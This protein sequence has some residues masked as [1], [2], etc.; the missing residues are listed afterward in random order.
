MER[1]FEFYEIV[2]DSKRL[3]QFREE[4]VNTTKQPLLYKVMSSSPEWFRSKGIYERKNG[5]FEFAISPLRDY[6]SSYGNFANNFVRNGAS[7]GSQVK[8]VNF[9]GNTYYLYTNSNIYKAG[10][11]YVVKPALLINEDIYNLTKLQF[12]QFLALADGDASKYKDFFSVKDTAYAS[13]SIDRCE[14]IA[15]SEFSNEEDILKAYEREENIIKSLR[16]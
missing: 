15:R 9:E 8:A 4:F 1:K 12:R 14:D 2:P 10:R 11:K 7:L 16:K 13:S 3:R 5:Y 6:D